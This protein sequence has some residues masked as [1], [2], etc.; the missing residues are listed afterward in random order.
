MQPPFDIDVH[1]DRRTIYEGLPNPFPAGR[2]HS[3][4][5]IEET[6]SLD[7]AI[8]AL[9]ADGGII[10]IRHRSLPLERVQFHPESLPTPA[11]NRLLRNFISMSAA[12]STGGVS[13]VAV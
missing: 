13:E 7:L 2:Y 8:T 12:T 11:G 3:L 5:V 10:R 4:A 1:H 9:T 6:P